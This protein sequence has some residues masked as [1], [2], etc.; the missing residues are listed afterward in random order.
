MLESLALYYSWHHWDVLVTHHWDIV[1]CFIW[2]L[3]ETS[4]R[5][6]DGTSLLRLLETSSRRLN[7][8]S[9][10]RTT[11]TSW[12]SSFETSLGVSFETYV[13][14]CWDVQRDVVT[15]WLRRLVVGW[16][17]WLFWN[18]KQLC[19]LFIQHLVLENDCCISWNIRTLKIFWTRTW[20]TSYLMILYHVLLFDLL[21]E[22][23][24]FIRQIC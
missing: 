12:W 18:V 1:G 10:R 24:L 6:T 22:N 19:K 5:R 20:I 15:T 2:E 13:R 9:W 17:V 4:R 21:K 3:S 14:P 11:K 23:Q 8:M 7:K 16:N